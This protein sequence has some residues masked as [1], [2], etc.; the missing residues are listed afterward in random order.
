MMIFRKDSLRAVCSAYTTYLPCP[1]LIIICFF[2]SSTPLISSTCPLEPSATSGPAS[3]ALVS[4]TVSNQVFTNG[5]PPC[6]PVVRAAGESLPM[7]ASPTDSRGHACA[8]AVLLGWR[9]TCKGSK[10]SS[11]GCRHDDVGVYVCDLRVHARASV[12]ASQ[13]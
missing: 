2:F 7:E 5:P 8:P 11:V 4:E 1:S 6:A 13:A 3:S 9:L 12:C 10:V